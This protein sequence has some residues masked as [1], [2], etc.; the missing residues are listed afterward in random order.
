MHRARRVLDRSTVH[1]FWAA[2]ARDSCASAF[3]RANKG[4]EWAPPVRRA[5]E[6][7]A[8][9]TWP[10]HGRVEDGRGDARKPGSSS[11]SHAAAVTA[12]CSQRQ[13]RACWAWRGALRRRQGLPLLRRWPSLQ[14]PRAAPQR[15]C[16]G[17]R[18]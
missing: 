14:L 1:A 8:A 12:A 2:R 3:K 4:R 6:S 5:V 11:A 10:S 17:P 16:L 18:G 7:R 13:Q 9:R 15:C